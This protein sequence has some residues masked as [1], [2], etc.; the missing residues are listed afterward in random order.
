LAEKTSAL[1]QTDKHF[2]GTILDSFLL[3]LIAV[4]HRQPGSSYHRTI[5]CF[6]TCVAGNVGQYST[7]LQ[8]ELE[9]PADPVREP[10]EG[11]GTGGGE[12]VYGRQSRVVHEF[13]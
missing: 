9:L 8:P 6:N 3:S 1:I 2:A 11:A 13:S 10:G 4:Q 7:S 5:Y 12:A